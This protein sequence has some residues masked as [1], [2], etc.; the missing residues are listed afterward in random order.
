MKALKSKRESKGE[1]R[2]LFLKEQRRKKE[3]KKRT[4]SV[5]HS[6]KETDCG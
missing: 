1:T 2:S 5:D 3:T 6:L 4:S